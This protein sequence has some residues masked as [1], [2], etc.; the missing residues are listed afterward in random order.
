[1]AL[2]AALAGVTLLF[3]L[4]VF[5][6]FPFVQ[7]GILGQVRDRLER[8]KGPARA[9]WAHARAYYTRLLGSQALFLLVSLGV[10]VP[11]MILVA[12]AA[13]QATWAVSSAGESGPDRVNPQLLRHPF[14][15]ASMAM[16]MVL[17]TAAGIVYWMANC[18]VVAERGNTLA[19]WRRGFAFC[20]QNVAAVFMV[21]LVNLV[22]GVVLAP[23]GMLGQLGVVTSWWALAALALAYSAITGYW[24][25]ILAGLCMSL[26]LGR[27]LPAECA[28]TPTLSA[29]IEP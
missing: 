12:A 4:V 19:G 25:V 24:G 6:A 23:L 20:R 16:A 2:A 3:G 26:F 8:P 11:V 29:G 14:V 21:W 13:I 18:V 15:L 5:F 22:V 28:E 1:V 27:H 9:F 17:L 10:I 7:G